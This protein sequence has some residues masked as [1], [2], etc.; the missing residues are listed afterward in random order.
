MVFSLEVPFNQS[1][2]NWNHQEPVARH[3]AFLREADLAFLLRSPGAEIFSRWS[4]QAFP[5]KIW[6]FLNVTIGFLTFFFHGLMT[7]MIWY[8]HGLDTSICDILDWGTIFRQTREICMD[9][10]CIAITYIG[11]RGSTF[12]DN[13]NHHRA[14]VCLLN[15]LHP[16]IVVQ[17]AWGW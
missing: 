7:W 10:G 15:V 12:M 4:F 11:L 8:P 9:S 1:S 16:K 6:G 13:I 14:F 2:K 3:L 5:Q 17:I